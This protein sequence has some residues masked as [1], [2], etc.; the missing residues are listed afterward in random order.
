VLDRVP[1]GLQEQSLLGVHRHGLVLADS[2]E[3]RVELVGTGHEAAPAGRPGGH[4]GVPS[5]VVREGRDRVAFARH[6]PPQL[7]RRAQI[8]RKPAAHADD[9]D[10]LGLP[11]LGLVQFPGRT[12]QLAG[13]FLQVL[14]QLFFISHGLS[15]PRDCLVMCAV[16]PWGD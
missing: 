14:T 2:E 11:Q 1:R 16:V 8:R 15:S 13:G 10:G 5:P 6:E 3:I 7:G 12:L 9:R 4:R